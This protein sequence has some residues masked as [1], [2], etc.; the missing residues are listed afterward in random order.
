[1]PPLLTYAT[2]FTAISLEVIGTTFLQRSQQFTQIVPTLIM[3]LCYAASFFFLSLVLKSMPL[4]IAYAI[5]SGMGI[6]LV[7]IVGMIVFNQRLD[8]PALIGIAMI[9]GGVLV[10]NL[11]SRSV[12]H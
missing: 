7:A 8:L 10:V 11:F 12:G 3:A 6:V 1:M 4:G 5:W 2:L 9:I